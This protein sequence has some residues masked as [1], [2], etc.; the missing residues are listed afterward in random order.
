MCYFIKESNDSSNKSGN[1]ISISSPTLQLEQVINILRSAPRKVN[2][3]NFSSHTELEAI[4]NSVE[5]KFILKLAFFTNSYPR[6]LR[7]IFT[8]L[9]KTIKYKYDNFQ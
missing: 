2:F 9:Q 5:R 4:Q 1:K 8:L 7:R 6:S 3:V